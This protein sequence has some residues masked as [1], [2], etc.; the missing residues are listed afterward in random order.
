[1]KELCGL[2]LDI[3]L[4]TLPPGVEAPRVTV[5]AAPRKEGPRQD[6]T[7]RLLCRRGDTWIAARFYDGSP[8]ESEEK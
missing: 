3:A 8:Q 1:M 6:G 5:T 4:S 7:L 2:P